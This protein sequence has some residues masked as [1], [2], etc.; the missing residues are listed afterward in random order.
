[1][2]WNQLS[3][4]Q[5][6]LIVRDNMELGWWPNFPA[7]GL[8]CF[9]T[10]NCRTELENLRGCRVI[11]RVSEAVHEET[12]PEGS[13]KAD[14]SGRSTYAC[15][16]GANLREINSNGIYPNPV[17]PCHT[18]PTWPLLVTGLRSLPPCMIWIDPVKNSLKSTIKMIYSLILVAIDSESD[19]WLERGKKKSPTRLEFRRRFPY[20]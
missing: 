15:S 19:L 18:S 4:F 10:L 8:C 11:S 13:W 2:K 3:K 16:L 14:K 17:L 7:T 6:L 20:W 1:M 12:T 9:I 5:Q